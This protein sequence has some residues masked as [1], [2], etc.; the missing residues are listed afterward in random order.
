MRNNY[1][2]STK[3][4]QAVSVQTVAVCLAF[5]F[6]F[7][8][9]SK[10]IDVTAFLINM[11]IPG[12]YRLFAAENAR[13]SFSNELNENHPESRIEN[14]SALIYVSDLIGVG[15]VDLQPE[16]ESE[17][18]ILEKLHADTFE[19]IERLRDIEYARRHFYTVDSRTALTSYHYNVDAKLNT[20]LR[21]SPGSGPKVLIFHTHSSEMFAN[22]NPH[23]LMDGVMGV[24]ERLADILTHTYGIETMHYRGRFDFVDGLIQ[25]EGAYE[26]ME[27]V[28][29]QI[30]R[31]N[32]SIEVAL[33]IHRDGVCESI[34]LVT[35]INGVPTAQIMFFNGL[36]LVNRSGELIPF[37]LQNPYIHTNMAMSFQ[38]QLMA[39]SL[40]PD[41][42]RRIYLNAYRYSLHMLPKS[43]LIEVGAQTNTKEEAFNAMEPL[44]EV[45]SQ[46]LLQDNFTSAR[47]IAN[48]NN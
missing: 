15:D 20:D 10:K 38:A 31:D 13:H 36:C 44:A 2:R 17:I 3:S 12:S 21:I 43:M 25:R 37:S 9:F 27:V 14:D 48:S 16:T 35:E 41:F 19:D 46:I 40:F 11:T 5:V 42:T 23:N 6:L 32:P 33:D 47:T 45:L 18:R 7:S 4:K 24:G 39:N 26:R 30:L 29:Q 34:R 22:S 8:L 28:I 1:S